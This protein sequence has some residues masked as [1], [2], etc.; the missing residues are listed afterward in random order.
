MVENRIKKACLLTTRLG[1]WRSKQIP[2][3]LAMTAEKR[4][5]IAVTDREAMVH[6]SHSIEKRWSI[7]AT[8]REVMVHGSHRPTSDEAMVHRSHRPTSDEA[9]VHRSHRPTSDEA[10]VH[11]GHRPT[12]DDPSQP[13][14]E[15]RW[16][17]AA[18]ALA[19]CATAKT[20][21]ATGRYLL[22]IDRS[23]DQSSDRG[24]IL[25]SIVFIIPHSVHRLLE[26]LFLSFTL[27]V[28]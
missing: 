13:L 7:A 3:F 16:S 24:Q 11:R 1:Q 5:S 6:R 18:T 27:V 20:A 26:W 10:M 23:N 8:D 19:G 28:F 4:L 21:E 14:T 2:F 17:I 15:K 12:S 22:E 9:M 25:L